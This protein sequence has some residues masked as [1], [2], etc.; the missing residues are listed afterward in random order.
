MRKALFLLVLLTATARAADIA[1]VGDQVILSGKLDNTE[2]AQF[3]DVAAAHGKAVST[4]ILRE[5]R[6]GGNLFE[7]ARM[8]ADFVRDQGWRTAV[9]GNCSG[10][11]AII[12]LGGVSRHFTDDK[13]AGFTRVGM[14]GWYFVENT[15]R[16]N[17]D[18]NDFS[19][20]GAYTAREWIKKST[21]GLISEQMLDLFAPLA[22]SEASNTAYFY[23]SRRL[24]RADGL[25]V[26]VCNAK[27]PAHAKPAECDKVAADI[28]K[29]GIATSPELIRSNDRGKP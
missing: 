8:A 28:Y 14:T 11:C 6:P 19:P 26:F 9:S 16:R 4:V 7:S 22:W 5:L 18:K 24:Q 12:F 29:E 2:L 1:V 21:Q 3:R 20:K 23:D 27:N 10:A 17:Y 25:S 15:K 13:P